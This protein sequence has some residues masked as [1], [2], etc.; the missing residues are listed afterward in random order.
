MKYTDEVIPYST[1]S[2]TS[3]PYFTISEIEAHHTINGLS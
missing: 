3:P 2:A 1:D